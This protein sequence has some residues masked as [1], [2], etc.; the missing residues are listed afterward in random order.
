VGITMPAKIHMPS[1]QSPLIAVKIIAG[2]FS[3]K[4]EML[5]SFSEGAW[6]G[7]KV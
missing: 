7:K 1:F 4:V 6:N 5:I 3:E 2:I